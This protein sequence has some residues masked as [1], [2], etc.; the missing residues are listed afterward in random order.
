MECKAMNEA[1]P[2]MPMGI[3]A[4][5]LLSPKNYTRPVTA[6]APLITIGTGT[7]DS[8]SEQPL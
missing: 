5:R 1:R 2:G 8:R 3:V 7:A 6:I 4:K